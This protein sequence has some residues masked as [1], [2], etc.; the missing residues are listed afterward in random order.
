M[1]TEDLMRKNISLIPASV[2]FHSAVI[3]RYVPLSNRNRILI[4]PP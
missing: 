3:N 4:F 1:D 2:S